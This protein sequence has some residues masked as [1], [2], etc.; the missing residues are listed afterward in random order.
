[1]GWLEYSLHE[2]DQ[3]KR[4]TTDGVQLRMQQGAAQAIAEIVEA[5]R[6]RTKAIASVSAKTHAE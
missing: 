4:L 3:T 1:M 6:G 2:L 5:V